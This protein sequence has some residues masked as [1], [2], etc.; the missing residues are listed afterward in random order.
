MA[1]GNVITLYDLNIA[2]G[3]T[4][5]PFVWATKFALRH[6]GFDIAL[7]PGGFT[8]ILDRTGGRSE[9]LPAIVDNGEWVL[10]SWNIAEHLD[11][12][13][14]D[15]PML[16]AHEGVA[17]STKVIERWLWDAAI[18][19]WMKCFIKD[20]RDLSLPQDQDY[21]TRSREEKFGA[22]L[23]VLQV[24]REERLPGI[25]ASL[26]P[27]RSALREHRWLGGA[28]PDYTD[29]R[30]IGAF[31]FISSI[32]T[33][34]VLAADDPLRDWIERCCDL[35]DGLGRHPGLFPLFGLEQRPG[36]PDLFRRQPDM[37]GLSKRNTGAQG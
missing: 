8:G 19:H 5:S 13:Y 24:G 12:K 4:L 29:Y 11:A 20:Y 18:W 35:Y 36:A 25:S 6:K 31:L 15:R 21:V 28:N 23:D 7:V 2:T 30:V 14:P 22:P 37:S 10:D 27:L 32:S 26:E 16:M 9:R 17:A 33:I 1:E 3:A 34:P